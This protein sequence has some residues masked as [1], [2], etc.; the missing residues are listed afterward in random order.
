RVHHQWQEI[1]T[2]A[3]GEWAKS[4]LRQMARS[5]KQQVAA[6]V[7]ADTVL[8]QAMPF[9][10][11]YIVGDP[12]YPPLFKGR[13]DIFNAISKVW[14]AKTNPDS[15]IVY[16]HRRMGKSSIVRNLAQEA[17][18]NS[19]VVYADMAGETSFVDSTATLLLNL[20]DRLHE[21]LSRTYPDAQLPPPDEAAYSSAARAQTQFS[22]L[23]NQ[24]RDLLGSGTL[25]LALDEFEAIERAVE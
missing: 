14:S 24:A 25:I 1:I 23:T 5:E 22:R 13:R 21:T 6:S 15:I 11:P 17:P 8:K 20:A 19:L 12:V 10:N 7:T 18:A 3:Q 16:G 2:T 4:S 9:D